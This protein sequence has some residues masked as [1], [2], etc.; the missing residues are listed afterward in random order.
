M[1]RDER[2][3]VYLTGFALLCFGAGVYLYGMF[4]DAVTYQVIS[5]ASCGQLWEVAQ[6]YLTAFLRTVWLLL[7]MLPVG[8]T[9][10]VRPMSFFVIAGRALPAGLAAGCIY[11]AESWRLYICFLLFT[12]CVLFIYI[13]VCRMAYN[14]AFAADGPA[15]TVG[16]FTHDRQYLIRFLWA[17]GFLALMTALWCCGSLVGFLKF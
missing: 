16:G 15:R 1:A 13:L 8:Y 4:S 17:C 5:F 11:R 6:V 12:A 10:F 14:C 7:L 2:F 3:S 9:R